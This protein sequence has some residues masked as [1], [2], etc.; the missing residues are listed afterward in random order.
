MAQAGPVN[1]EGAGVDTPTYPITAEVF[2]TLQKTVV[3]ATPPPPYPNSILYPCQLS[4]YAANG[5]GVWGYDGNGY[6]SGPPC[7]FVRPPMVV[8]DRNGPPPPDPSVRDPLAAT[9]LTFF[10][11]SDMHLCDKEGP[12]QFI[13]S[14]YQ[15]PHPTTPQGPVGNCAEYSGIILS[16]TQV[17]DAAI[18]TINA[19]HQV[20]PFDF[21]ISLGDM[22]NNTHP[23][24]FD[25]LS[26]SWT[27]WPSNPVPV[28]TGARTAS[29]IKSPTS[30]PGWT[31]PFPGMQRWATMINSGWVVTLS[32]T[33]S[34]RPWWAPISSTSGR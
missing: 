24:N 28:I 16:T 11:M 21:G 14:S 27:V 19:L 3:P 29:A 25:G 32:P 26:M 33:T 7:P 17:L 13:Y 30:L 18:Q 6:P 31:G 5:Y 20:T 8:G 4:Q 12:A 34:N 15:Y 10:A 1:I 2:T 22:A 23:M 9:L